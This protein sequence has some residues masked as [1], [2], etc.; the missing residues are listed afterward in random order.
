MNLARVTDLVHRLCATHESL[1][2]TYD[3]GAE[4][5]QTV[6]PD[7]HPRLAVSELDGDPAEHLTAAKL[8]P[9]SLVDAIPARFHVLTHRGRP[10]HL[11]FVAH[12]ITTDGHSL[13]VLRK[14]WEDLSNGGSA[15]PASWQPLALA[16]EQWGTAWA[17]MRLRAEAYLKRLYGEATVAS[18]EPPFP[19]RSGG[20]VQARLTSAWLLD[21]VARGAE[22][23]GVSEAAVLAAAALMALRVEAGVGGLLCNLM[24]TNRFLAR[25][26]TL[27][28]SMSQY[29]PVL[30]RADRGGSSDLLDTARAVHWDAIKAYRNG[31]Y[32]VDMATR[33]KAV[34]TDSV[35]GCAEVVFNYIDLRPLMLPDPLTLDR[36]VEQPPTRLTGIPC[37]VQVMRYSDSLALT[38][39]I[40][41]DG[42]DTDQ[43]VRVVSLTRDLVADA[44]DRR[45]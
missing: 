40:N 25:T 36:I 32:S 19:S 20:P 1:R 33:V 39:R 27:V 34:T 21:T 12:H 5:T 6:H 28:S 43:L 38:I 15:A 14:A 26:E 30:F 24:A 45:Q 2:T 17:G 3:L 44:S 11:V 29:A 13:R 22:R 7:E 16:A 4:P 37:T 8:E 35:G 9:F 18:L 23:H 10:R 31:C 42:I 41:R